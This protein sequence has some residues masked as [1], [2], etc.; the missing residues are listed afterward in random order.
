MNNKE[1]LFKRLIFLI[2]KMKLVNTLMRAVLSLLAPL[3]PEKFLERIPVVGEISVSL[4]NT[5]TLVLVS[6]GRD[7]I[8]S[9]LYW[10][11]LFSYEPGTVE[12]YLHLLKHSK[13]AFDVGAHTG[14]FAL[15]AALYNRQM[16][17][18]AFEPV[19]RIFGYLTKNIERN[20]FYNVRPVCRVVSDYD[21]K[22]SFYEPK[23]V[24][25]PS[26]ASM[27]RGFT[28]EKT[29]EVIVPTV[30][31]DTFVKESGI[32]RVDLLKIDV[33]G[34]EDR[35]LA[36][37]RNILKRDKPSIICEVIRGTTEGRLH[38]LFNQTTYRFFRITGKGLVPEDTVS[39]GVTEEDWNYLFITENK[40]SEVL[41]G[42]TVL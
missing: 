13:V 20:G 7:Q 29:E 25:L 34:S 24:T 30:S 11:G 3:F 39:G 2:V 4:P 35:V 19:P 18:Y 28:I 8:A 41:K 1:S 21:G 37:A 6:D 38:S 17:V 42:L 15:I 12:I 10:S 14:L 26:S 27:V 36:G 5:G 16:E 32:S 23:T 22:V 33:E 9:R 31:L 40:V